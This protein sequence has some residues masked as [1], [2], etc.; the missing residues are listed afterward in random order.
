MSDQI[1]LNIGSGDSQLP[2]FTP[3]DAKFGHDA[4]KLDYPDGSV[5]EVYSSHCLEHIHHSKVG[6]TVREWCRVLKPGGRI[7]IAIPDFDSVL[8]NVKNDPELFNSAYLSAWLHGTHDVSTDRHQ[9]FILKAD[10]EAMLRH[11]GIEDI[12]AWEGEYDDQARVNEMTLNVGG[13][14]REV[15][16]PRNPKVVMVLSTPRFGPVDMLK[17]VADACQAL[18]WIFRDWGG[19]EW[20]KGLE[21]VCE[22]ILKT[23]NPDYICTLDYDSVF[24]VDDLRKL[25]AFMQHRPD[26]LAAWPVQAHRHMDLPLGMAPAGAAMGVYDFSGEFTKMWSG[27]FGCTMIRKQVFESIPHP[28]FWSVPNQ[29]TGTWEG[30]SDADITFWKWM[31]LHGMKFGQVNTVQIGHM[32]WCVKWL[33][34]KGVAWQ[35]IQ[36]YK[37]KGRPANA[38]FVGQLWVDK[39]KSEYGVKETSPPLPPPPPPPPSG[40]SGDGPI[41]PNNNEG[42]P[43]RNPSPEPLSKT[44]LRINAAALNG[45]H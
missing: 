8:K 38:A 14:K 26:V 41:W 22:H 33:T 19:T 36:N 18:G 42:S 23:E 6:D 10:L 29:L 27:H 9:A 39:C 32:E 40:Y 4:G 11:C 2:G 44:A 1:R 3:I 30:S 21:S 20:G 34:P 31:D 43:E 12:A 25:L 5:D 16:I 17:C 37:K 35:P 24:D 7:R 28:W 15:K 13:F 45:A